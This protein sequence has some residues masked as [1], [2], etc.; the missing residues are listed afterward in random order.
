MAL[1]DIKSVASNCGCTR[2]SLKGARVELEADP[3]M[4]SSIMAYIAIAPPKRD[5]DTSAEPRG[6][7]DSLRSPLTVGRSAE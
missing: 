1:V 7:T 2:G 3:L 6:A 4:N 5:S